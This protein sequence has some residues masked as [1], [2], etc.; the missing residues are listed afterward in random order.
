VNC[1]IGEAAGSSHSIATVSGL[2]ASTQ[3]TNH[4]VAEARESAAELAR[5]SEQLREAI[6]RSTV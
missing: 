3:Q 6:T 4:R 2:A 5:L 1:N